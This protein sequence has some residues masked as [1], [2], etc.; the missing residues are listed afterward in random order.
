MNKNTLVSEEL[1]RHLEILD[2]SDRVSNNVIEEKFKVTFQEQEPEVEPEDDMD[3]VPDIDAPTPESSQDTATPPMAA[4]P[5][6]SKP[7]LTAIPPT[8]PPP[9][10]AP[11]EQLAP[12]PVED[13]IDDVEELDVTEL[14]Q[15][16]DEIGDTVD[17]FSTQLLDIETK[18]SELT[19]KLDNMDILFQ[20]INNIEVEIQ[21]MAP[22]TPIEKME[23]RSL[24]SFPYSQR[25]DDYFDEKKLQYK[26]LRG[27]DLD[28][29]KTPEKEYTLTV[30]E[31][32]EWDD[33]SIGKSFSPDYDDEIN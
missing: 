4:T 21:K 17:K 33:N 20:K 28:T 3:E 11:G 23:L 13:E 1:K 5:Q 9:P 18:F 26:K 6:V 29:R 32:D 31:A 12:N 8:P 10:P 27:I 25:L 16:N 7:P 19:D 2:Y 22:P 14:V 24:D 30:G 15:K